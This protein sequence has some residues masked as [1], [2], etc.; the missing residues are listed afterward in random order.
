MKLPKDAGRLCVLNAPGKHLKWGQPR[1][2]I[3]IWKEW[4]C[5]ILTQRQLLSGINT[6]TVW[7]AADASWGCSEVNRWRLGARGRAW[8]LL[9]HRVLL[10]SQGL[11][12]R[13]KVVSCWSP[14]PRGLSCDSLRPYLTGHCCEL[15][16]VPQIDV[17][18]PQ[19]PR[20]WLYVKTRPFKEVVKLQWGSQGGPWSRRLGSLW[21]EIR[22]QTHTEWRKEAE[23]RRL[24]ACQGE[25]SQE[26][27]TL[28][29]PWPPT[30]G[31]S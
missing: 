22:T 4:R 2:F 15:S 11:Q 16:Y 14:L 5:R 23:R 18:K 26:E 1:F 25:R 20:M 12:D 31:V 30:S 17:S 27:P 6:R 24:S 19:H 10:G 9:G 7:G 29:A 21:E 13:S 8:G 28:P 3:S